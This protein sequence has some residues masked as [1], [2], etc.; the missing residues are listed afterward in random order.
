[1][2]KKKEGDLT[3]SYVE[4]PYTNRKFK[5]NWQHET[6]ITQQECKISHNI[7]NELLLL[8]NPSP[9]TDI[10]HCW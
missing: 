7:V 5:T 6:S 1:M 3:Q 10:L 2:N 8:I 4:N 9:G